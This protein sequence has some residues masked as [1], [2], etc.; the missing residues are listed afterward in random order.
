MKGSNVNTTH[1]D[2]I[3]PGEAE[4][5]PKSRKAWKKR[6]SVVIGWEVLG[7]YVLTSNM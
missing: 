2:D 3:R 1:E 4:S 5:G 7:T 6:W